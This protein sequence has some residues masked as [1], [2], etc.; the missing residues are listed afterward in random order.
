MPRNMD[1]LLVTEFQKNRLAPVVFVAAQFLSGWV[2]L[3]SGI[4]S[5][6]WNGE[7]WVG[8]GLPNGQVLGMVTSLAESADQQAQSIALVLSAAPAAVAQQVLN[9][10]RPGFP[11]TVYL[12]ASNIDTG[13]LVATPVCAW[14]GLMD[15]PTISEAADNTI[16]IAISV[17]S[18]LVDLRRAR[19]W[20]YTDQDQQVLSPG[21]LGFQFVGALQNLSISWGVGG[22]V[23]PT[24]NVP[25]AT[26]P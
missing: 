14:G 17:E 11:V 5:I 20:N 7:T 23:A 25:V 18:R 13:A 26:Q 8:L 19:Q 6:N 1:T 21:D 10:C 22:P 4:G 16:A 15:I 2:Y 3:W 24:A 9:E 12:G